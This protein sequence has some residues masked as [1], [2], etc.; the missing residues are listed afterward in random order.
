MENLIGRALPNLK[1]S[2]SPGKILNELYNRLFNVYYSPNTLK[3][4]HRLVRNYGRFRVYYALAKMSDSYYGREDQLG[5]DNPYPLISAIIKNELYDR[6]TIEIAQEN[7]RDSL[8]HYVDDYKNS[9]ANR[10]EM[11]F[12]DTFEE[13]NGE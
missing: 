8:Q 11:N 1:L 13:I 2:T 6:L 3:Q 7:E 10:E 9:L 5:T 12:P 4:F